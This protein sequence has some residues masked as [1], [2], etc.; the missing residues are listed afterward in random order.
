VI[1]PPAR[2]QFWL[3]SGVTDV[4][5]GMP[6]LSALVTASLDKDPLSGDV[7]VFRG[8]RGD[9]IKVLWFSG[10]GVNLYIKC[11][12]RDRFVWPNASKGVALLKPAQFSM[13]CEAIDWRAPERTWWPA[14]S[15][16]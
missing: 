14:V 8:R 11:L 16:A 3:A 13:L 10:D 5:N 15:M 12:E 1:N 7:F 9:Q 2:S 6:G 4:C